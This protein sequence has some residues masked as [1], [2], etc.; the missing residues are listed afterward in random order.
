MSEDF[1]FLVGALSFLVLWL[2]VGALTARLCKILDPD[3]PREDAKLFLYL[4]WAI[5]IT[6]VIVELTYAV[7]MVLK[8]IW[9]F[10]HWIAGAK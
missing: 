8:G 1:W 5:L 6:L 10:L 2:P 7:T 4:G 9:N 3:L